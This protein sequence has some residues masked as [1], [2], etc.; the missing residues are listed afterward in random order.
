MPNNAILLPLPPTNTTCNQHVTFFPRSL[1]VASRQ[2]K[3]L[4]EIMPRRSPGFVS[5]KPHRKSRGGC[6][7]CKQKKVKVTAT[8]AGA[9]RRRCRHF[10][11]CLGQESNR[12]AV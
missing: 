10:C 4:T 8:A 1:F 12:L 3:Q 5:K 6:A 2:S 9:R 11:C 7:M